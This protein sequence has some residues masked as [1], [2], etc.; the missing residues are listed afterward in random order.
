[1]VTQKAKKMA[2]Q[3]G[4]IHQNPENSMNQKSIRNAPGHRLKHRQ[5]WPTYPIINQKYH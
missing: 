1:M 4:N 3:A 2:F 5:K